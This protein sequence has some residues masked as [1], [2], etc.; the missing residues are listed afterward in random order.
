VIKTAADRLFKTI[1]TD[2]RECGL[3]GKGVEIEIFTHGFVSAKKS[4]FMRVQRLY[5]HKP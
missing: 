2:K 3:K 5:T 1:I 4:V